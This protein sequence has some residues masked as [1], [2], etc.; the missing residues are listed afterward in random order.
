[1]KKAQIT[2]V[3]GPTEYVVYIDGKECYR[4]G[5][6]PF[7]SQQYVGTEDVSVEDRR[8]P[9]FCIQT[10]KAI[11]A[12]IGGEFIGVRR[13]RK[14]RQRLSCQRQHAQPEA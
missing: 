8:M 7:D 13:E 5:N 3:Y 4:A 10:A 14:S 12:E 1:M 6:S 2:G 11:A 9:T